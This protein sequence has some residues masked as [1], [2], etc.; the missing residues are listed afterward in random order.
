MFT[1]RASCKLVLH[2]VNTWVN[3][4]DKIKLSYFL[5]N[6]C[7]KTLILQP[8]RKGYMER[9]TKLA[10]L[11]CGNEHCIRH[12]TVFGSNTGCIVGFYHSINYLPQ[13][14]S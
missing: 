5:T 10:N 7:D 4:E 9:S 12:N 14:E 3:K 11:V 2:R 6:V 8:R 1:D 13:A